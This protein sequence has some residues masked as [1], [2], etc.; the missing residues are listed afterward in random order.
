MTTFQFLK[1]LDE[2][3]DLPPERAASP[4]RPLHT[5]VASTPDL[6]S[7]TAATERQ[8]LLRSQTVINQPATEVAEPVAGGTILGI[9]NLAIVLPQFIVRTISCY[10][11]GLS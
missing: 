8:P 7:R 9:H 6:L 4:S 11:S 3:A 10:L 5:R 1:E 2:A